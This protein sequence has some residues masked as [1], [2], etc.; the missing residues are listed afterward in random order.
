[1]EHC[2]C[3]IM[4]LVIVGTVDA[5]LKVLLGCGIL[6]KAKAACVIEHGLQ[7]SVG[8]CVCHLS[9]ALWQNG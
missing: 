4:N 3:E 7:H 1:M 6:H 5:C 9:D 2:G 8:L